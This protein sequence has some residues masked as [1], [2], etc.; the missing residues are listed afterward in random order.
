[1][2][3]VADLDAAFAQLDALV[4]AEEDTFDQIGAIVKT[5]M[6]AGGMPTGAVTSGLLLYRARINTEGRQ[7][8]KRQEI[9]YRP[10]KQV[11]R[12]GRANKPG[13]PLFYCSD[14]V[15]TAFLETVDPILHS[16]ESIQGSATVG[17]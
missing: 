6:P 15:M 10:A 1:M 5:M 4:S 14:D 7:F 11:A 13:Q 16:N 8:T 12:Y 17:V 3:A 9:S 2:V